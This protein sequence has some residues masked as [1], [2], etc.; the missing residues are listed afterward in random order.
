[1]T[2][3]FI[4]GSESTTSPTGG[5]IVNTESLA[6]SKLSDLSIPRL[7]T[8][9]VSL[10]QA[11]ALIW[12]VRTLDLACDQWLGVDP[13]K[14]NKERYGLED[15]LDSLRRF[16]APFTGSMTPDSLEGIADYLQQFEKHVAAFDYEKCATD[17]TIYA[18]ADSLELTPSE[19]SLLRLVIACSEFHTLEKVFDEFFSNTPYDKLVSV[20][21]V[22]FYRPVEEVRSAL[23][24]ESCLCQTRLLRVTHCSISRY[25]AGLRSRIW[26][27]D[28]LPY[29]MQI[30]NGD[31]G[32]LV[33]E[34]AV[35]KSD[36]E[37]TPEDFDYM[38]KEWEVTQN[39]LLGSLSR[40]CKGVNIL[41][42]GAP[43][44]GKTEFVRLLVSE[45]SAS[46][47]EL[48]STN[49][50][51]RMFDAETR[52]GN[53]LL[54]SKLLARNTAS[55]MIFDDAD[56]SLSN[57]QSHQENR[58]YTKA[59]MNQMLENNPCP[60]IW[61]A[62]DIYAV[63]PSVLRRFDVTIPFKS[64]PPVAIERQLK[65]ILPEGSVSLQWMQSL[66]RAPSVTPAMVQRL[67]RLL[68]R[69]ETQLPPEQF[70]NN[71][72]Q[73]SGIELEKPPKD[74]FERS[75][76][77]ALPDVHTVC[78]FLEQS[79]SSRLLL[80][81]P[82]GTGKTALARHL[83]MSMKLQARMLRPSD[84]LGSYVGETERNI[85][86]VFTTANPREDLLVLDEFEALAAD[87]RGAHRNWE[88]SQV[89]ELLNRL[90][91]YE[92][93]II[94]CTNLV[95]SIDPAIRRRFHLKARVSNLTIQQ[96]IALVQE[97]TEALQ[98][99]LPEQLKSRIVTMEGLAYGHVWNATQ[100]ARFS[101]PSDAEGFLGLL[102]A[103]LVATSGERPR[104]I[105]F[106]A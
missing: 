106:C 33:E 59:A 20:L 52:S 94:A 93:R 90:D 92:G 45:A 65:K 56:D 36:S 70:L 23:S 1:M 34:F 84:I 24:P 105:G 46:G 41:V 60:T 9:Q 89:S 100:V 8:L 31:L 21:A 97:K 79:S 69:A 18:L 83:C 55:V 7:S 74:T 12:V 72:L 82:T 78:K 103:E 47:Y 39:Y 86:R 80:H 40:Q 28:D 62:N 71:C 2:T 51:G 99:Q 4:P 61:V 57:C 67:G 66:S 87:R 73:L 48:R 50:D 85:A 15:L 35:A 75:F 64:T 63:D 102:E 19:W 30:A 98:L 96:R 53:Y 42:H 14:Y 16:A 11:D 54:V 25:E 6:D 76:C 58:V 77:N 91:E 44:M 26:M 32:R 37:L 43:G 3:N 81:G 5:L 10:L 13:E 88:V 68:D 49:I 101:P 22:L 104:A 27:S 38:G 17:R 29:K 95:E